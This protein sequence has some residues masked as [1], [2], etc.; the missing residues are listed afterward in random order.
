[1]E[2]PPGYEIRPLCRGDYFRGYM[3]VMKVLGRTGYVSEDAWEERCEWL[4]EMGSTYLILVVTSKN[5]E[6]MGEKIIASGTLM[7]E[8]KFSHNMGLVGH[9]EDIAIGKDQ[10]GK[11]MGIRMLQAL[12]HVATMKGCYKVSSG[13]LIR[14]P[15][16]IRCRPLSAAPRAM[17][18]STD[19]VGLL[20]RGV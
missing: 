17:R 4:R 8:H 16:L 3:D 14:E 20:K 10:K 15:W 19:S 7:L 13:R 12:L 9:I 1:M 18:H 2:M 6:G 11:K 5:H